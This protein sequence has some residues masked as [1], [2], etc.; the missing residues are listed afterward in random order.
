MTAGSPQPPDRAADVGLTAAVARAV[1]VALLLAL[2]LQMFLSILGFLYVTRG[3]GSPVWVVVWLALGA[4]LGRAAW[5]VASGA[6]RAARAARRVF[7]TLTVLRAATT[8]YDPLQVILSYELV[9]LAAVAATALIRDPEASEA[10][11]GS[12]TAAGG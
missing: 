7:I 4:V 8:A 2:S 11:A 9:M 3:E 12:P 6:P 5:N 10:G 1:V